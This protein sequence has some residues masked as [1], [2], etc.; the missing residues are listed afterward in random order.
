MP[1][2]DNKPMLPKKLASKIR[3]AQKKVNSTTKRSLYGEAQLPKLIAEVAA[4]KAD[5]E[6]WA[7]KYYPGCGGPES[8][9]V[10]WRLQS[11][12]DR[13]ER[14]LKNQPILEEEVEAARHHLGVVA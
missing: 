12:I 6:T 9:P 3:A 8:Y 5:P 7:E 11:I 13:L 1:V 4:W 2:M 14:R 10:Q